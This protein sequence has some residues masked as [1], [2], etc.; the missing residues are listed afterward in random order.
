[1]NEYKIGVRKVSYE[2]KEINQVLLLFV[3]L[4]QQ[5]NL[6]LLVVFTLGFGLYI[7]IYIST[8]FHSDF[9]PRNL[10]KILSAYISYLEATTH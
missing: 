9:D 6:N 4:Q 7:Y 3:V 5:L 2:E 8:L 1:M 10:S